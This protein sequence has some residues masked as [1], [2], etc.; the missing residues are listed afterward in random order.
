MPAECNITEVGGVNSG[1]GGEAFV[2]T[3][4]GLGGEVAYA[5]PDWS[6]SGSGAMG[7]ASGDVSYH[8]FPGKNRRRF[9][10]FVTGGYSLYFGDRTETQS[11]FNVGGGVNIWLV[12]H[13]A[14]R[15]EVRNQGFIKHFH[16]QFT[17]F[18]AFRFGVTFR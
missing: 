3:G 17:D 14:M 16:S 18:V 9:E 5:G 4:L 2:F 8:F 12:K 11:G 15:L 6:F 7:I 13:A 10:P 1:F